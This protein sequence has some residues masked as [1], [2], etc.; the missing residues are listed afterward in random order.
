[1]AVQRQLGLGGF[2]ETVTPLVKEK[3]VIKSKDKGLTK[4]VLTLDYASEYLRISNAV[5]LR[6][7][8]EPDVVVQCLQ[9]LKNAITSDE[10][11]NIDI[12]IDIRLIIRKVQLDVH[13]L[14]AVFSDSQQIIRNYISE[15]YEDEFVDIDA[16]IDRAYAEEYILAGGILY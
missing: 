14:I 2:T 3:I 10:Y 16:I 5:V 1:M 9:L 8:P 12:L 6:F 13:G 11:F 4:K 7:Y 15:K